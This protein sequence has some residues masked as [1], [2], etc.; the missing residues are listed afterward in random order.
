MKHYP[1]KPPS[2]NLLQIFVNYALN[3]DEDPVKLPS[4]SISYT[5]AVAKCPAA[6]TAGN[7]A[8]VKCQTLT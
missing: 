1:T 3:N 4:C 8:C 6:S 7:S 2:P 5:L